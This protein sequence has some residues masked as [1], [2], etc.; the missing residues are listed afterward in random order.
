MTYK[1]SDILTIPV[2][3]DKFIKQSDVNTVTLI[4]KP[5]LTYKDPY[6]DKFKQIDLTLKLEGDDTEWF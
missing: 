6:Y 4:Y 3:F 1:K 2:I 5:D